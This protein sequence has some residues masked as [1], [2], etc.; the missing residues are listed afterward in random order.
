[1]H[2][3]GASYRH[4]YIPVD[5]TRTADIAALLRWMLCLATAVIPSGQLVMKNT[6]DGDNSPPRGPTLTLWGA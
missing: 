2:T 6:Y 3:A 1:M 5:T 4:Y